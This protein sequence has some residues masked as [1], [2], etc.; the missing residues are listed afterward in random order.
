MS[1]LSR[2]AKDIEKR[3]NLEINL[4]KYMNTMMSVYHQYAYIHLALSY[5]T[6]GAMLTEERQAP[7][8][9]RTLADRL[10]SI[11][12]EQVVKGFVPD[13]ISRGIE[14]VDSIR[15]EIMEKMQ[16]LTCYT[17]FFQIYEYVLNRLEYRFNDAAFP[18]DYNDADFTKKIIEYILNDRDNVVVHTKISEIVGQLPLRMTKQR[19]FEIVRDS[20]SLYLGE[21]RDNLENMRYMLRTCA[22]LDEPKEASGE[23]E[24]LY[25]V[26]CAMKQTDIKEITGDSCKKLR[27]QLVFAAD[28]MERMSN[29]YMMMQEV[30]NDTY[31]ILLS[32]PYALTET[33]EIDNCKQIIQYVTERMESG[34]EDAFEDETMD[35]IMESFESLE[36]RQEHLYEQLSQNDYLLDSM[37]DLD[38]TMKS[39]MVDRLFLSLKQ[40]AKLSSGS[41][42]IDLHA[43]NDSGQVD[44]EYLEQTIHSFMEEMEASF[45][46]NVKLINRARMAGTLQSLPAF[47]RNMEECQE[48][49]GQALMNCSD[50]RE[51]LASVA[52]IE[53]L[54][55]Q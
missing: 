54:M 11:I 51:K 12:R 20:F 24:E 9:V 14:A 13:D 37:D 31:I 55:E 25:A 32:M 4:P 16:N 7:K 35:E 41:L 19:Y 45:K 39:I 44:E 40:I 52:L 5:Y 1:E 42:F 49:I 48:Y 27:D 26:Y 34:R 23:W 17:D 46:E 21:S 10:N 15:T 18:A 33:G 36:G 3:K 38:D 43:K 50:E 2:I 47:F 6:C 8:A 53:N 22:A 28:Y 29:L 30:V